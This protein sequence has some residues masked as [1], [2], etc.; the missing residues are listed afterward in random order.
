MQV[1]NESC[2]RENKH[3][4]IVKLLEAILSELKRCETSAPG[5][6]IRIL[7]SCPGSVNVRQYNMRDPE[8]R[9][10]YLLDITDELLSYRNTHLKKD[11]ANNNERVAWLTDQV[12]YLLERKE[13]PSS[14]TIKRNVTS[15]LTTNCRFNIKANCN[16]RAVRVN[17]ETRKCLCFEER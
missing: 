10:A 3:R 13:T 5:S 17:D 7:P 12:K 4:E 14:C 8:S 1:G 15:C 6:T 11:H 16:L 2:D 9:F